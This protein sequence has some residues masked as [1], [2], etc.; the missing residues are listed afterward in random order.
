MTGFESDIPRFDPGA[1]GAAARSAL[2]D[3]CLRRLRKLPQ[4][5]AIGEDRFAAWLEAAA[6]AAMLRLSESVGIAPGEVNG[7]QMT[8]PA[9]WRRA[10]AALATEIDAL[11]RILPQEFGTIAAAAEGE[12]PES[13]RTPR[14]VA[15]Q[16][17]C[18]LPAAG[19]TPSGWRSRC[20]RGWMRAA[21]RGGEGPDLDA[22]WKED[23]KAAARIVGPR[24]FSCSADAWWLP[25]IMRRPLGESGVSDPIV[26]DYAWP[27]GANAALAL[28]GFTPAMQLSAM[29]C[30]YAAAAAGLHVAESGVAVVDPV[31]STWLYRRVPFDGSRRGEAAGAVAGFV[32]D[33]VEGCVPEHEEEVGS[34][35]VDGDEEIERLLVG[36]WAARLA[37]TAAAKRAA[38]HRARLDV[39]LELRA[40]GPER[41]SV[42]IEGLC[43]GSS[44]PNWDEGELETRLGE[45][46]IDSGPFLSEDGAFDRR[47][48]AEALLAAGGS[49]GG[50]YARTTKV[51]SDSDGRNALRFE[52]MAAD[53]SEKYVG[54][55]VREA[56]GMI[57]NPQD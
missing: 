8:T 18:R 11:E 6:N 39:A 28:G 5:N 52:S 19:L 26:V 54:D 2:L 10:A 53:A 12:R 43:A 1:D 35:I 25:G 57:G 9:F 24:G 55:L 51:T 14:Q 34:R 27:G 15:L 31:A 3:A 32:R 29:H 40:A 17:L 21:W 41:L 45:H 23:S 30:H 20:R 36:C 56:A 38:P 42:A 50:A 47:A 16:K 44:Y 4:R 37:A 46:G 48:A 49:V 7:W 13:G 22:G 33:M